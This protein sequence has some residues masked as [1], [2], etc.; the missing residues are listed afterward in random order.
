M[1][2]EPGT[3]LFVIHAAATFYL[4]GLIWIVQR[5]H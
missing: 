1:F 3:L 5:V 2:A 4:A